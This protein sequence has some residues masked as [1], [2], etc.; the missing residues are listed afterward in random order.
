MKYKYNDYKGIE[1]I[2]NRFRKGCLTPE[3]LTHVYT[4]EMICKPSK[5][6]W[7]NKSY[8]IG[9]MNIYFKGEL[10]NYMDS[11][12]IHLIKHLYKKDTIKCE[13]LFT[14]YD[15]PI[16][17]SLGLNTNGFYHY[18]SDRMLPDSIVALNFIEVID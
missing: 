4:K 17:K 11:F 9:D 3:D 1:D 14:K 10:D 8:S 6:P 2:I 7:G 15:G 5:D 13:I 12:S 16:G 18:N